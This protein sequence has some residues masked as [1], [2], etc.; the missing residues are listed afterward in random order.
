ME[1]FSLKDYEANKNQRLY[2]RISSYD[3]MKGF[4]YIFAEN[5]KEIFV[6]SYAFKGKEEDKIML[7][8]L[9]KFTPEKYQDKITASDIE[10]IDY[11]PH[12]KIF[13]LPNGRKIRSRKIQKFGLVTV[14]WL[15]KN[16][17]LAAEAYHNGIDISGYEYVYIKTSDD[18]YRIFRN[19]SQV[20]AD[21]TVED[22]RQYMGYL[23]KT[24]LL[25]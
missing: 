4:G 16:N 12:E 22:L 23:R 15:I 18:L 9:L 25:L 24:F 11:H 3:R 20:E 21:G 17:P 8:T 6:S 14:Q 7:G 5:G 19:G 10:I 2:G 13:Q 1:R